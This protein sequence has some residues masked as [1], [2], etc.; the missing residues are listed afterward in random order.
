M[1]RILRVSLRSFCSSSVSSTA[2]VDDGSGLGHHVEGDGCRE[3]LRLGK[4]NGVPIEGQCCCLVDHLLGLLV[5]LGDT[6][7]AAAGDRLV[8]RDDQRAQAGLAV[9]RAE[10]RH[11]RHRRAVGVGDDALG[12]HGR[13]A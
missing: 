11:G 9:E 4:R 12:A 1:S 10:D 5:E 3:L 8:G 6:S 2:V 7:Q 13:A